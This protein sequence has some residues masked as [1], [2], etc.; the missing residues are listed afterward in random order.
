MNLKGS[1]Q[2]EFGSVIGLLKAFTS[3]NTF[4]LDL[5]GQ[6]GQ[7]RV[8]CSRGPHGGQLAQHLSARRPTQ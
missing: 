3:F 6:L 4:V 8:L 5:D 1:V 7:Q 2:F